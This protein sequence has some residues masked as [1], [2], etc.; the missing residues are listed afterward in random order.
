[1]SLQNKQWIHTCFRHYYP[2]NNII[3]CVS[4]PGI[5][6][7]AYSKKAP[8]TLM[9]VIEDFFSYKLIVKKNEKLPSCGGI[10]RKMFRLRIAFVYYL[11]IKVIETY[12][13]SPLSL[14]EMF[15]EIR[16]TCKEPKMCRQNFI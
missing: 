9:L 1:M 8:V 16:K 7:W 3:D 14:I 13:R 12:T 6:R 2:N 10:K 4:V 5:T 11:Y 15:I